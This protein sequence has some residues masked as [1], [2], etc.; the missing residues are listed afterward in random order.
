MALCT[1]GCREV[2]NT[3]AGN[4]SAGVLLTGEAHSFLTVV[5][6]FW[7]MRCGKYVSLLFCFVFAYK[8]RVNVSVRRVQ[9]RSLIVKSAGP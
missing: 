8:F 9:R 5:I 1:V 2:L 6:A 4:Y 7:L 3:T